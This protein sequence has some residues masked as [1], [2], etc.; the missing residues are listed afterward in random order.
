MKKLKK[1]DNDFVKNNLSNKNVG[2]LKN[3]FKDGEKIY[4][5]KCIV[6]H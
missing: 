3:C 2:N 6:S 5:S 4:R 1:H